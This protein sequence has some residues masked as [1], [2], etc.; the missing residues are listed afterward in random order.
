MKAW[1][2]CT[3]WLYKGWKGQFYPQDLPVSRWFTDHYL[4]FFRTVELGSTFYGI[5]TTSTVEGWERKAPAGFRYTL[6][7]NRMI[8][9]IKKF[10]GT[11]RLVRDFYRFGDILGGKMGCFLFQ[12]PPFLRFEPDRLARILDQLDDRWVN[13]LEFRDSSWWTDEVR[14]ALQKRRVSFCTVSAPGLPDDVVRTSDDLY[15]RFHG[16]RRWYDHDYGAAAL[17]S[18]AARIRTSGAR[19]AWIYFNNDVHARAPRNA[20]SL[21]RIL[22]RARDNR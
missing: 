8:T 5:P 1:V 14:A 11:E 17:K 4:K 7:V 19:R 16:V 3:G 6:K 18:W 10:H 12:L 9:H 13:V 22:N 21:E 15:V 2:G 20:K